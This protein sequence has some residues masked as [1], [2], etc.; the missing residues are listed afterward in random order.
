MISILFF[1]LDL[2]DL[3]AN[4]IIKFILIFD[5]SS[6]NWKSVNEKLFDIKS[7]FENSKDS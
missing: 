5:F 1:H 3:T 7:L 4:E 2:D 6:F